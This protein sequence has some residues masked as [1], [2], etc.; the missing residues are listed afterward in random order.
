MTDF[1]GINPDKNLGANFNANRQGKNAKPDHQA[2]QDENA[3]AGDPYANLK[4]DP[5]RMMDLLAAQ[6]KYNISGQFENTGIEKSINAFSSMVSPERHA[7]VSHMLG[8]AFADE[9]GTQPSP[10][11]LQEL[12]DN[13]LIG[14][15]AVQNS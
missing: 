5:D 9:F 3:T 4:M 14:H 15:V 6:A 11:I 8:Q 10:E 2:A 7:R 12:V 1:K 13:Y